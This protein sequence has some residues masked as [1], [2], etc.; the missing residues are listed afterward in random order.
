MAK[1][2]R[3][4][5]VALSGSAIAAVY[6]AGLVATRGA[7]AAEAGGSLTPATAVTSPAPTNANGVNVVVPS[8]MSTGAASVGAYTDGT[9]QRTGNSRFGSISVSVTIQGGRIANVAIT[10]STTSFPSR[11]SPRCPARWWRSRA[12]R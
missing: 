6:L 11:A 2:M 1:R 8:Q 7:A 3:R 4:G 10:N 12:P 5:L 9:Y